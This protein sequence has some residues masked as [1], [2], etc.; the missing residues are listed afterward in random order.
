MD[1]HVENNEIDLVIQRITVRSADR[2]EWMKAVVDWASKGA[3]LSKGS[4]PK[5]VVPFMVDMEI[6]V[7]A[8]AQYKSTPTAIAYPVK[9]TFYTEQQ[10][11]DMEWNDFRKACKAVGVVGRDKKTMLEDYLKAVRKS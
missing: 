9:S 11:T 6:E 2:V 3:R 10:L 8:H 1:E 5:M 4:V 7:E